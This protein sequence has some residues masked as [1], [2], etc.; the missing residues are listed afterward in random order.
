MIAPVLQE[1]L[2][3][4]RS[5]LHFRKLL[6]SL[7]TLPRFA[8]A[9]PFAHARDAALLYARCRWDG[10][11][12]RSSIDCSIAMCAIEAG[13]PLLHA[14]ADFDRIARIDA[15]LKIVDSGEL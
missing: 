11:T 6:R 2:Q 12:L 9:N 3:G 4:A 7:Q 15:R 10:V 1:L 8:P 13:Q 5:P 14:D